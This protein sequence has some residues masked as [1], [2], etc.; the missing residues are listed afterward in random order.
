M[1]AEG[2]L[3]LYSNGG[4]NPGANL[5]WIWTEQ[6]NGPIATGV[7]ARREQIRLAYIYG[8]G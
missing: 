3:T 5:G 2:R 4:P 1:D 8:T 6:G 7:G